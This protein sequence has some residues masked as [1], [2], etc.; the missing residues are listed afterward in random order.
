MGIVKFLEVL[1]LVVE[2]E[3]DKG[4]VLVFIENNF[5]DIIVEGIIFIKFYVLWC[6][7]CKNLVFIWEEFFRKE[8]FGL[9]GVKIVEVDCI[10]E[11]S[12]C[13]KYLV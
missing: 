9:V 6:G 11:W 5:D 13:S 2:F 10:V 3:V 7:Y 8:F 1:V 4:I 12:I